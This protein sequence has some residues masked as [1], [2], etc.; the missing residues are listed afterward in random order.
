MLKV[1]LALRRE[2]GVASYEMGYAQSGTADWV[3]LII[4]HC[5]LPGAPCDTTLG[6]FLQA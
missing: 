6:F 2:V 3:G 1:P 4:R 5:T